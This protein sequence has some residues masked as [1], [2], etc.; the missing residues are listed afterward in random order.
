MDVCKRTPDVTPE[1]IDYIVES[2]KEF[3]KWLF[4]TDCAE[5]PQLIL[6]I[7]QEDKF[8]LNQCVL[9]LSESVQ[10]S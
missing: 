8:L 5:L 3:Y 6:T 2:V 1:M 10:R 9:S 4:F 7:Y